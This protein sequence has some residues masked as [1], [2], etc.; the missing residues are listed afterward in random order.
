MSADS[1]IG[2]LPPLVLTQI[3]FL[4]GMRGRFGSTSERSQIEP[5][6]YEFFGNIQLGRAKVAKRRKF[7]L[8]FDKLPA[9]GMF[10]TGQTLR[11]S[12]P[13][14]LPSA[15]PHPLLLA[16]MSRPGKTPM[17][18]AATRACQ[19]DVITY[20]SEKDLIYAYGEGGRGVIYAQQHATGQPATQGLARAVSLNP[21]TGAAHFIENSSIQFIDKNSGARP[22][23]ATPTDPDF[24]KKKPPKTG[25]RIPSSNVER[26]GFTGQ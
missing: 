21:K 12:G 22:A 16:T 13:S 10:L 1:R 6:W 14:L 4:K 23:A 15:R 24:K 8:N 2:E 11:V 20:D 26:R 7:T 25:F 9:D 17:S 19:A 3:H 5:H 18:P